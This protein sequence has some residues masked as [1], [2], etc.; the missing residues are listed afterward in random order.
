MIDIRPIE[1][2]EADGFLELLCDVF[3][4]DVDRARGVFFSEPFFDLGRKWGLFEA[5]TL[6]SILTTVPLEFGWGRA[7]G[8]AGVATRP[9]MRGRGYGLK[10]VEAAVSA[11]VEAGEAAAFLFAKRADLYE[12]AGFQEVDRV[13]RMDLRPLPETEEGRLL[14]FDEVRAIYD[15]WA[16]QDENRLRRSEARWQYWKWNLRLCQAFGAGYVCVEGLSVRE[17]IVPAADA[18]PLGPAREW[19]GLKSMAERF[20]VPAIRPRE[21]LFLMAHGVGRPPE[22]FMTDQF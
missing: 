10:L 4:L 19:V 20:A 15:A 3:E 5:G 13:V 21:E 12:R 7:S 8:I 9:A 6:K 22:M 11:G 16:L 17:A 1:A 18:W 14:G 2:S